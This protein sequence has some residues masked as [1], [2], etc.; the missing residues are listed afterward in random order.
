MIL[1]DFNAHTTILSTQST[2][3]NQTGKALEQ[4]VLRYNISITNPI[5]FYTHLDISTGKQSC[6]DLI[7]V[8]SNLTEK[9]NL[10]KYKDVGSDHIPVGVMLGYPPQTN[11]IKIRKK[12]KITQENLKIFSSNIAQSGVTVPTDIDTLNNDFTKRLQNSAEAN[13]GKTKGELKIRKSA[14]WWDNDCSVKI[15]ERRK[16]RKILIKYPSVENITN[17]KLLCEDINKLKMEKKKASFNKFISDIKYDTP[18]G[19][20]WKKINSL[21]GCR[22]FDSPALI[23]GD[24]V[25]TDLKEK[26]NIFALQLANTAEGC[27]CQRIRNE[28]EH[29]RAVNDNTDDYNKDFTL[30]ELTSS[31]KAS[32]N[33]SPEFDEMNYAL[34]KS[35][36][37]KELEDLLQIFNQNFATAI[38]PQEWKRGLVVPFLKP[39]KPKHKSSSYRMITMLSCIGKLM[40]IL[41]KNRLEFIIESMNLLSKYQCGFRKGQ[42]TIDVLLIIESKIRKSF[43]NSG[44]CLVAYIDLKGAFDSVWHDGLIYKLTK[45]GI[46]GNLLK[47]LENYF[48]NREIEVCVDGKSNQTL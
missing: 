41:V 10:L 19:E 15:K 45:L 23:D 37:G 42:G 43:A 36:K 48:K 2:G 4:L 24:E 5:D 38:I 1:G 12:W 39:F 26:A 47:W 35:L 14:I 33:T 29:Q 44:I 21:K 6:L 28:D 34:I 22:V 9:T 32:R 8:S 7:L 20:V 31:L 25:I 18:I 30:D 11:E 46:K 40:E 16:A 13:I 27:T 3:S 17:Y